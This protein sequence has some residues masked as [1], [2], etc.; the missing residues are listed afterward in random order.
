MPGV[1]TTTR[2]APHAFAASIDARERARHGDA[3]RVVA[4][5]GGQRAEE[6]LRAVERVHPDA[7]A[8]Q[9]TAAAPPGGVDGDD[10]DAHLVG[11]VET[12]ATQQFVGE[13]R[14]AGTAGAGDAHDGHGT[15][16]PRHAPARRAAT[17]DGVAG[18]DD[19]DGSCQL[20]LAARVQRL[21]VDGAVAL[22]A[23]RRTP[24][25]SC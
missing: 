6:H 10:R 9:R 17:S 2:S 8:Q 23:A 18:L 3:H 13:R 12:E 11:L 20:A 14:L 22:G 5:A 4:R 21:E 24:R 1:S 19:G 15:R 16:A 7:V 25:S